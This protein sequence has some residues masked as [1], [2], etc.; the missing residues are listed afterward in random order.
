MPGN[1][2][3]QARKQCSNDI[4]LW[5]IVL[6]LFVSISAYSVDHDHQPYTSFSAARAVATQEKNLS[7]SP[8]ATPVDGKST[9]S[10]VD[11]YQFNT[12]F[13]GEIGITHIGAASDVFSLFGVVS[14]PVKSQ[15]DFLNRMRVYAKYGV[16]VIN[17]RARAVYGVGSDYFFTD[18]DALGVELLRQYSFLYQDGVIPG[19]SGAT[20]PNEYYTDISTMMPLRLLSLK[21]THFMAPCFGSCKSSRPPRYAK[22]SYVG[23]SPSLLIRRKHYGNSAL[24]PLLD[25]AES[26]FEFKVPQR[27]FLMGYTFVHGIQKT[28]NFGL[29]LTVAGATKEKFLNFYTASARFTSSFSEEIRPYAKLGLLYTNESDFGYILG[30]GADVFVSDANALNFSWERLDTGDFFKPV[31][32]DSLNVGIRHY[33]GDDKPIRKRTRKAHN[34][35]EAMINQGRAVIEKGMYYALVMGPESASIKENSDYHKVDLPLSGV[36]GITVVGYGAPYKKQTYYGVEGFL[37]RSGAVFR[38]KKNCACSADND[39]TLD[40]SDSAY[41]K[42]YYFG[43]RALAGWTNKNANLIFGHL[44]WVRSDWS[45]LASYQVRRA[46]KY[47]MFLFTET[48]NVPT[49]GYLR[50]NAW[51]LGLGHDVPLGPNMVFRLEYDYQKF[52]DRVEQPSDNTRYTQSFHYRYSPKSAQMLAGFRYQFKPNPLPRVGV[53]NRYESGWYTTVTAQ[54]N[55]HFIRKYFGPLEQSNRGVWGDQ[56]IQQLETNKVPTSFY[57]KG[58]GG[59]LMLSYRWLKNFG[60]SQAVFGLE[61]GWDHLDDTF[62]YQRHLVYDYDNDTNSVDFSYRLVNKAS[63]GCMLGYL[64]NPEDMMFVKAHLVSTLIRRKGFEEDIS[65]TVANNLPVIR[66]FGRNYSRHMPG[67]QITLGNDIAINDTLGLVLAGSYTHYQGYRIEAKDI[68]E[69]HGEF[70]DIRISYIK[71]HYYN[72]SITNI[73]YSVGLRVRLG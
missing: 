9:F 55:F 14:A 2:A 52:G 41:Y 39:Y 20:Y 44:G 26:G 27:D 16:S 63:L 46:P 29:E 66:Y 18:V 53:F 28:E 40:I 49:D 15:R 43:G 3:V 33:Y 38:T 1:L 65:R 7:L 34:R 45:V 67:L 19:T 47:R 13:A 31:Y 70:D 48:Q 59:G 54:H 72:Y 50:T 25:L 32:I 57:A 17:D 4:T 11:G 8:R 21:Y 60:A 36:G 51:M 71:N 5:P 24:N 12:W 23:V 58:L 35:W 6:M 22:G 56:E 69:L 42:D 37:G 30:A 62:T 61:L 68:R 10:F 73:G 64:I